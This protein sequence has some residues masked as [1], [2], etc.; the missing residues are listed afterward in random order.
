MIIVATS[1]I[2][3]E[4]KDSPGYLSAKKNGETMACLC[5]GTPLTVTMNSLEL[6]VLTRRNLKNNILSQKSRLQKKA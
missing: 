3:F 2:I 1:V 6:Q 5:T 4:N